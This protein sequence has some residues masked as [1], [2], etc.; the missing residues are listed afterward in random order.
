ML[1]VFACW[2]NDG[3]A[4]S[5]ASAREKNCFILFWF[6]RQNTPHNEDVQ[7]PEA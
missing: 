1:P 7:I 2:A 5:V 4:K 3:A 6:C